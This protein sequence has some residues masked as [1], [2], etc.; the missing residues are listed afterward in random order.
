MLSVVI[1]TCCFLTFVPGGIWLWWNYRSTVSAHPLWTELTKQTWLKVPL[2]LGGLVLEGLIWDFTRPVVWVII[3]PIFFCS[4]AFGT[5][6]F[7]TQDKK[8]KDARLAR[9]DRFLNSLIVLIM[10]VG[11]CFSIYGATSGKDATVVIKEKWNRGDLSLPT[12]TRQAKADESKPD[13]VFELTAPAG[14]WSDSFEEVR[15]KAP[16]KAI[17]TCTS[18]NLMPTA[19][20]TV[21][22]KTDKGKTGKI[23][24]T[25]GRGPESLLWSDLPGLRFQSTSGKEVTVKL[26][27]HY[28]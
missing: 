11:I 7:I 20:E 10:L 17:S 28:D 19:G 5:L 15:G 23:D 18:W 13:K 24:S 27:L 16:E 1:M 12:L 2:V 25:P 3:G 14:G 9:L 4:V 8:V 22:F 21:Q 6:A 26:T